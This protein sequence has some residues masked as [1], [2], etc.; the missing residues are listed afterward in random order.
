MPEPKPFE[1]WVGEVGEDSERLNARFSTFA[2]ANEE[3]R[4]YL[5][6]GYRVRLNVNPEAR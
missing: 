3:C 2:R 6:H 1:V 5:K 4:W